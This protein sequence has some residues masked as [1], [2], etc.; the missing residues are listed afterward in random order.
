MALLGIFGGT[1]DPPHIGHL[2]LAIEAREALGLHEI[3]V[4]PA[5]SPPLRGAPQSNATDRLAMARLAFSSV[6][7]A[8]VDEGEV[9]DTAGV[10]RPSYTV[11][12]LARLRAAEG[13]TRPMVLLLGA[14]AFSRLESWHRWRE[15]FTLAHVG[16]ATRP[17]HDIAVAPGS[18]LGAELAA[19]RNDPAALT[20]KSA[21]CV[22]PFSITALDVS[23]TLVRDRLARG[24]DVAHLV[25]AAVLDYIG[26]HRLYQGHR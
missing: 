8:V 13:P 9:A 17:G 24:L 26:S 25:P 19:R 1:F 12:T 4:I 3:R 11:D 6:A 23:A 7:G 5:G 18:A 22:V 10:T 21:G 16:V 20:G 2:R 14:D 15:L